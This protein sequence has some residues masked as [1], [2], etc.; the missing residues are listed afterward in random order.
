MDFSLVS[1]ITGSLTVTSL[2]TDGE[3]YHT[4]EF[5]ISTINKTLQYSDLLCQFMNI[6]MTSPSKGK[7]GTS[8]LHHIVTTRPPVAERSRRLSGVKLTSAKAEFDYM[9]QRGIC[10][11]SISPWATPLHPACADY[12]KLNA[13]T[14]PDRY[15]IT[16]SYM[17]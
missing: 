12:R 17:T 16:L 5:G 9:L 3:V 14:V 4:S 15:P 7:S 13:E 8:V 2:K 11:L 10:R 1:R 6:I